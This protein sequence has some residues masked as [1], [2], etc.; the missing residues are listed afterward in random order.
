EIELERRRANGRKHEG[1]MENDCQASQDGNGH[2]AVD[3]H[4]GRPHRARREL[5]EPARKAQPLHQPMCNFTLEH[6]KDILQTRMNRHSCPSSWP[7][8]SD[9]LTGS[10]RVSP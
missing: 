3:K 2:K 8:S 10:N 1:R 5:A 6:V 4:E 7:T 9:T